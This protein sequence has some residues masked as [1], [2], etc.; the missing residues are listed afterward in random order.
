MDL[1]LERR[2]DLLE[3]RRPLADAPLPEEPGQG[4]T[5]RGA[6]VT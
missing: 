5:S 1:P 4:V 6:A 2:N 3:E